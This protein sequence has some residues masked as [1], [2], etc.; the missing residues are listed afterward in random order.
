VIIMK[1]P[2]FD[3]AGDIPAEVRRPTVA[4]VDLGAI[5]HNIKGIQERVGP[6]RRLMAMVKA[7]AYG[8]GAVTIAKTALA[9]GA[10]WLGVALPEEGWAL[11]RAGTQAPILVLGPTGPDQ[12]PLVLAADLAQ[13]VFTWDLA[14]ALEAEAARRNRRA[15][16]HVKVDTG[17]GRIGLQVD[18]ALQFLE[19]LRKL[20]HV[21]IQG[22]YT[23][24]ATA[25]EADKSFVLRQLET[26]LDTCAEAAS[27]GI[28]IPLK[29]VSNSAGIL[30]V[31]ET[32]QDLVRPGIMIY[33]CYPSPSVDRAVALRPAM[34]WKTRVAFVKELQPGDSVSYGRT[35]VARRPMRVAT[36]PV[37]Y[38]DGYPRLLSNRG[39]VLVRERR[40]P[41]I[42]AVCMDMTMVDVTHIQGASVGDEV[43][44]F[45]RQGTAHLPVEE[46]AQ[47]AGTISYEIL[48]G[49]GQ[50]VPRV[51]LP[52][53][54][55]KL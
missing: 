29:H 42:G 41:V 43:V 54:S 35:F 25:D 49:V 9:S 6:R 37:G 19:S 38:G 33:G 36:L 22:I 17:M 44:L 51:Y 8:H 31:P 5:G 48:C 46:V 50:R 20:G 52:A 27:R 28:A 47:W 12:V 3:D 7:N 26:F 1:S 40:A 2:T 45:G 24:L 21:D 39:E 15:L 14:V 11:R 18:Q 53:A 13:A 34:T 16:V 10:N 55:E 32:Y 23:H 4:E 30:D